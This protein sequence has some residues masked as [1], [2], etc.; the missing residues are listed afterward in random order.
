MP[1]R[2][3]LARVAHALLLEL[4]SGGE[5]LTLSSLVKRLEDRIV[6]ARRHLDGFDFAFWARGTLAEVLTF[7]ADGDLIVLEGA[8]L[9]D[10][11]SEDAW[12]KIFV[13][14]TSE[15]LRFLQRARVALPEQFAQLEESRR[16][17]S[18]AAVSA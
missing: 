12:E 11:R 10:L 1:A 18:S 9:A 2:H 7:L 3:E 13:R 16:S 4:I 5:A 14:R 6:S 8:G 17:L 15:G